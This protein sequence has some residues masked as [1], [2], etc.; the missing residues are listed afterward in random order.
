M[1]TVGSE[2]PTAWLRNGHKFQDTFHTVF[3][4]EK[5]RPN[6]LIITQHWNRQSNRKF[7]VG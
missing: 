7:Q 2:T 4:L 3:C 5:G 6:K 1:R